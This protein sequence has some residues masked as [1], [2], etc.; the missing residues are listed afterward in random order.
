MLRPGSD[1]SRTYTVEGR[2]QNKIKKGLHHRP[3]EKLVRIAE[4][5]T[6]EVYLTYIHKVNAKSMMGLLTLALPRNAEFE[7]ICEGTDATAAFDAVSAFFDSEH[8]E[9]DDEAHH[10][11][12]ER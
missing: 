8:P 9:F 5:F 10:T 12:S 2:L 4:K 3:A 1:S 7:V 11:G 6:C